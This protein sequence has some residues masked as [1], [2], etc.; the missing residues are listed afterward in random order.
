MLYFTDSHY[1]WDLIPEK[2][3]DKLCI[4]KYGS[5]KDLEKFNYFKKQE[6]LKKRDLQDEIDNFHLVY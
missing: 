4:Q 1:G 2:E 3:I 6:M 5:N